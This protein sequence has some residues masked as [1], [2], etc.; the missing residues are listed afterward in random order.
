M[1]EAFFHDVLENHNDDSAARLLL[2]EWLGARGDARA[3]GY[4]YMAIARKHPYRSYATWEWWNIDSA[5]EEQIRLPSPLWTQLPIAAP[6]G[7]PRCKEWSSRREA[8]DALCDLLSRWSRE[9]KRT[10]SR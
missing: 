7:Y 4:S 3:T 1:D 2:A 6:P 8:E 10:S 5:N 9:R